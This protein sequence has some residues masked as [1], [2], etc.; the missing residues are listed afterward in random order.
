MT[1]PAKLPRTAELDYAY[2]LGLYLGDG[3][4]SAAGRTYRLR[5]TL[6]AAYPGIVEQCRSAT[7]A[8][9]PGRAVSNVGR[10]DGAL[11]VS[12]YSNDWPTFLPQHGPGRKHER[13]IELTEWQRRIVSSHTRAFIRGLFH[14]DGCYVINPTRAGSGRLYE[15]DRYFFSNTSDDIRELFSWA[16]SLIG[17]ESRRSN[18]KN[19]SVARR[20]SVAILNEFLGP[21]A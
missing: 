17:V 12:C 15:Y 14:S 3:Y 10:K 21:K 20:A 16:C 5:I 6:D 2:L 9:M 8:V 7:A 13:V 19:I 11:D 18:A 4:V 1:A